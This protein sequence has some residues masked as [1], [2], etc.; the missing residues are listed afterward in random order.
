MNY[1]DS[2][3]RFMSEAC[4][5]FV[6]IANLSC[7]L[8][9]LGINSNPVTF[10]LRS[11]VAVPG[12]SLADLLQNH[13]TRVSSHQ[14]KSEFSNLGVVVVHCNLKM[15]GGQRI[16]VTLISTGRRLDNC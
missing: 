12:G 1:W 15:L 10:W 13:P 7:F 5:S 2:N 9:D 3:P 11:F 16:T 14:I 8:D 4:I 6:R